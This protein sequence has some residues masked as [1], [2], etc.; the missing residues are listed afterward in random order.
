MSIQMRDDERAGAGSMSGEVGDSPGHAAGGRRGAPV[1]VD[2]GSAGMAGGMRGRGS[3]GE[4]GVRPSVEGFLTDGA[5]IGMC[6]SL[7][8]LIG[9]SI[10][11][12]V[13]SG[14]RVERT[15]APLIWRAMEP[16]GLTPH[17][18]R[19]WDAGE[20]DH[21]VLPG[22]ELAIPMLLDGMPAG[23][24]VVSPKDDGERGAHTID[25][26][27]VETLERLAS[28]IDEFCEREITLRDSADE[29]RV[30]YRLSSALTANR[31]E[32]EVCTSALTIAA[33][34]VDDVAIGLIHLLD[35][36]A[37]SLRLGSAI[38][39]GPD[40]TRDVAVLPFDP[41]ASGG[42]APRHREPGELLMHG[43]DQIDHLLLNTPACSW[44]TILVA[45]AERCLG[46]MRL[47]LAERGDLYPSERSVLQIVAEQACASIRRIR[48]AD[49]D[50]AHRRQVRLAAQVQQRMFPRELPAYPGLDIAARYL[51]SLE[52]GGDFYDLFDLQGHLG[53]VVADVVGKGVPAG[54]MMASARAS[55]RA[56]AVGLYHLNDVI[57]RVNQDVVRD[58]LGHEFTT[59]FYG[60]LD[61]VTR[62]LTYCNA[63][64]EPPLV[65]RRDPG[66]AE[67][68]SFARLEIGG[69]AAGID[70]DQRYERAVVQLEPG[71]I[72]LAM[73]DGLVE[74][75]NFQMQTFG[76]R[77]LREAIAGFLREHPDASSKALTDHCIWAMRRFIGFSREMD[78]TTVLAV[79]IDE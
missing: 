16:D 63:G 49:A 45:D 42:P 14:R 46:V 30:L 65:I 47:G 69:M 38:G 3:G 22:G 58:T 73:T 44:V 67:G 19:A 55:L 24:F 54:L 74:A 2:P 1:S 48:L 11:V 57:T 52:V 25:P 36:R 53:I 71:D 23:A 35:D 33:E 43:R 41:P 28:V 60:V 29:L 68:Y 20:I 70:P 18:L 61:P 76:R 5:L 15:A 7:S 72:L 77:R 39:L 27:L 13:G 32:R 31:T 64:H 17:L 34:F 40:D 59:I 79:R 4:R 56:H 66:S 10:A 6:D 21:L 12:Y 37:S 78:D 62:V 9:Q 75:M 8:E 50:R 26:A 51:A